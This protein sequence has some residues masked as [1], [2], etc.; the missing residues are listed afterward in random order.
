MSSE[1][2]IRLIRSVMCFQ[3]LASEHTLNFSFQ[4]SWAE[5]SL[6][7]AMPTSFI[8]PFYFITSIA[9]HYWNSYHGQQFLL[10]NFH[11]N[12]NGVYTLKLGA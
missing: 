1:K 10:L 7:Q 9:S 4:S 12:N 11:V 5:T 3:K 2:S 6:M 8:E